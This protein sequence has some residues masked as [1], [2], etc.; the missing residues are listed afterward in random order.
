MCYIAS[1]KPYLSISHFF[2]AQPQGE[3]MEKVLIVTAS[4]PQALE[5]AIEAHLTDAKLRMNA[6]DLSIV[7]ATTCVCTFGISTLFV[8]TI[9]VTTDTD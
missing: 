8:C 1:S 9:V 6:D 4:N 2:E 7:A 5:A 3:I